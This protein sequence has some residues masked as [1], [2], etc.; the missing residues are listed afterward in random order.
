MPYSLIAGLGNPGLK[1]AAT[2][3]NIGFRVIDEYARRHG[4]SWS[5]EPRFES[6]AARIVESSGGPGTLSRPAIL[7]KPQAFMNRSGECLQR[8][9]RYYRVAVESVFVIY[10]DVYLD[11]GRM[12][13]SL[14]GGSGGHNGV[15]SIIEHLGE[16]FVRYRLG[17]GPKCPTEMDL[18]DFVL[19]KFTDYQQEIVDKK[20]PEYFE[21]LQCLVDR[22]PVLAMNHINKREKSD[23]SDGN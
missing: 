20:M 7:A 10:D 2:R 12:K 3:H 8:I 23:E 21:G 16:K 15:E 4:V 22:G 18:K 5:D 14:R 13:V 6:L 11:L 19:G 1:Y 17:V 9:C